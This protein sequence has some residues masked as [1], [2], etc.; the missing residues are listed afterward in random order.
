[1]LT[2]LYGSTSGVA[3][4][5]AVHAATLLASTKQQEV[6]A[7][8]ANDY[9][10]QLLFENNPQTLIFFVSTTGDGVAPDNMMSFWKRLLNKN[11]PSSALS[12]LEY[13]VF[14]FGDSSY[15][16]FNAAARRLSVRLKQLGAMEVVPLGMGD[17]QATYGYLSSL[18]DWLTKLFQVLHL[19]PRHTLNDKACDKYK[20]E[21][22]S[23]DLMST[24]YIDPTI[25]NNDFVSAFKDNIIHPSHPVLQGTVTTNKLLTAASWTQP[26]YGITIHLPYPISYVAGDV[27]I[28]YPINTALLVDRAISVIPSCKANALISITR[29][30]PDHSYGNRMVD[31]VCSVRDLFSKY[32]DVG[33]QPRRSFFQYLSKLASDHEERQKL[34]ELASA[35]GCDLFYDYCAR[36]HRSYIEVLEEFPSTQ[37]AVTLV[38][39]SIFLYY[40]SIMIL[41]P[42]LQEV[43]LELVPPLRPRYFSL[44]SSG[45]L[46]P[47]DLQ[48]SVGLVR[49]STPYKRQREGICSSYL[50]TLMEGD[51]VSVAV[52]RGSF[53]APARG[54]D[55]LLVGPGTGVAPM[56]ALLL[57]RAKDKRD[58][59]STDGGGIVG[60]T[61]LFF[62][63]RGRHKD[64][65]YADDWVSLGVSV[66]NHDSAD[67]SSDD[68]SSIKVVKAFSRD[69]ESK[70]Y[71]THRLH[72][73][74][75]KVWAMLQ[76]GCCVFLS[77]SA[78]RMPQDVRRCLTRIIS[79]QGGM[80]SEAAGQ[81]LNAM[82]RQGRYIAEV[83]S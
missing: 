6:N 34:S 79:E 76:R 2:I 29:E 77:G 43:L 25:I 72:E 55:L 12:Q 49:Y 11:I 52:K 28:I 59:D 62:G 22:Q 46:T 19:A 41:F 30:Y 61:L 67:P 20:V 44:A 58:G 64:D 24:S 56:R 81:Y 13:A 14:G 8:A 68:V 45:L 26:V 9:N 73:Y 31:M 66:D 83:W 21:F 80:S 4:D 71:V 39:S 74:R 63:C 36:E 35:Q 27:A 70:I 53:A 38:T 48:L 5:E 37:A 23:L 32:L 57:E 65:L 17:D 10:I 51:V 75:D 1:M 54:T 7:I 50:S 15:D 47:N 33:G 40:T 82:D 18:D 42:S 69:Q 60:E 3:E 16:K 78:K